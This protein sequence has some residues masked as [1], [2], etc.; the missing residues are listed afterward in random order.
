M[1]PV[2]L[3]GPVDLLAPYI[4]VI[5][6]LLVLAN[7]GTRLLAF[8]THQAQA[9]EGPEAMA[10]YL[11]HELAN[12]VLILASFYYTTLHDHG[13]IVLS[14]MVITMVLADFFEFEARK[15]EVREERPLDRPK[16]ALAASVLALGY[17]LFQAAFWI[18]AP[19]YGQIV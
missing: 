13:G 8:K 2:Q 14:A 6:V 18:V 7:M 16:A 4:E 17:A 5:L 1:Q 3:L 19:F 15:V 10:R 9:T 12:V 11:P